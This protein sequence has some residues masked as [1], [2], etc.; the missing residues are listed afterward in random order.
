[1]IVWLA[2]VAL[3]GSAAMPPPVPQVLPLP[4]WPQ[5]PAASPSSP[6]E[7]TD[8]VPLRPGHPLPAGLV[9]DDGLIA[10]GSVAVPTSQVADLLAT[11]KYAHA[12]DIWG[13]GMASRYE[14]D[15]SALRRDL[16]WTQERLILAEKPPPFWMKPGVQRELGRLDIIITVGV[17]GLAVYGVT[18]GLQ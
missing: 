9:G 14:Y 16:T 5:R 8:A 13:A 6:G 11:K 4:D 2:A 15:T 17:V 18:R 1:M 12:M 3:A 7:C 10:C